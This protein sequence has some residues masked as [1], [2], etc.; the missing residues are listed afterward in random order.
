[1]A[2]PAQTFAIKSPLTAASRKTMQFMGIAA[3]VAIMSM[4]SAHA[5]DE[6][7]YAG[8][9]AGTSHSKFKDGGIDS[10]YSAQG[11]T[12]ASSTDKH[13]DPYSL[14]LGYQFNRNFAVEG[15][16]VNLGKYDFSSAI[17][18]PAADTVHGNY[19]VDGWTTSAVGILPLQNG[20]AA[21]GKLGALFSKTKFEPTSDTG[22][23]ALSGTSKSG[24]NLTY[25]LG[26]KYAFTRQI[27][28]KVEWN[29]YQGVGDTSTT[30]KADIDAYTVGVAYKF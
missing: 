12:S 17:S 8:V 22:V 21:Y 11:V 7:W 16:Y 19:K 23:T 2:S 29:R 1:M 9:N 14:N 6:G 10:A 20:F 24:T 15:G 25:G 18:S 30:G 27:D 4:S 13:D 5:A 28:G 26:L 3:S